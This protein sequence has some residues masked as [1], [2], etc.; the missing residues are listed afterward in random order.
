MKPVLKGPGTVLFKLGYDEP[1]S[2]FAWAVQADPMVPV[3]KR[4][5]PRYDG[6][7]SSLTVNC[8]FLRRYST[9]RLR[10]LAMPSCEGAAASG[11][12]ST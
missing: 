9:A 10:S 4:L 7:L 3:L 11:I 2:I 12:E 1:L 6:L 5:D 8:N